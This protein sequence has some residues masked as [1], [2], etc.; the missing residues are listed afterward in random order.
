MKKFLALSLLLI[1]SHTIIAK[2]L[3][4]GDDPRLTYIG[5]TH[6]QNNTMSFDWSGVTCIITF[7]GTS[8][9]MHYSDSGCSYINVWV[10]TTPSAQNG[11]TIKLGGEGT[12]SLA[13]GLKKGHHTVTIQK[14]TEGK[15]GMLNLHTF[16]TDGVFL[17]S[18]ELKDR[19]I[20]FIGD[21]YTCG[22]GT[23]SA[24]RY[25][26]FLAETE[27]CNLTYAAI[28]GRYFDAD[29]TLISHSGRGIA[30]NYNN[31]APGETMTKK[32]SQTFDEI[33]TPEW[34]ASGFIPNIVVIYLGTNDFSK[35]IQ[36]SLSS[37]IKEYKNLLIKI[38]NNYGEQVP[39]LCVA[40]KADRLLG[41]YVEQAVIESGI[42]NV[43]WTSIQDSAHND[44][45]DLGAA[46]H[47]NY[48]G[49]RKVASCIIPYISTLTGWEMPFKAYE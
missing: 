3:I 46:D 29:I 7:N 33:E 9:D 38:R 28:A 45:S 40:S 27:N 2:E 30:R 44:S 24:S 21:S 8:L 13:E 37:W 26:K 14:R 19:K 32:Y 6:S 18:R 15:E 1:V 5:R 22:Y 47:P 35:R 39:I 43:H 10:D 4:N 31:I 41:E 23:E 12:I 48:A 25:D 17:Q 42:F 20:E 36:P 49:Q 11:T 16:K 34:N